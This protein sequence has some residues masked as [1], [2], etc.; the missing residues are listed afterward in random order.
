M[1]NHTHSL[2]P[3]HSDFAIP[4]NSLL[5]HV[6]QVP[7]ALVIEI[8]CFEDRHEFLVVELVDVAAHSLFK[9]LPRPEARV[10]ASSSLATQ[11][12]QDVESLSVGQNPEVFTEILFDV[13]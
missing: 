1:N 12:V 9:R 5:K 6:E 4:V 13:G 3:S 7:T 11:C 10:Q 8:E 2:S